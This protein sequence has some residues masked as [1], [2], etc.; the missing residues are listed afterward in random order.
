MGLDTS[1][2]MYGP[3]KLIYINKVVDTDFHPE[4]GAPL[5]GIIEGYDELKRIVLNVASRFNMC[6][7]MGFDIGITNKGF[8]CMEI[9]THPGIKYLQVFKPLMSNNV[10]K[11]YFAKRIAQI[12]KMNPDE[13]WQRENIM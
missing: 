9:N 6:S 2:G 5:N 7:Y 13:K 8:K 11:D 10:M 3:G 4:C 1:D 12:E